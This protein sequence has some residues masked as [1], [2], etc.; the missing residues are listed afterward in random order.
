MT[1]T[2]TSYYLIDRPSFVWKSIQGLVHKE[3][4]CSDEFQYFPQ[5]KLQYL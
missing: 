1:R 2:I 5:R 3:K 4:N